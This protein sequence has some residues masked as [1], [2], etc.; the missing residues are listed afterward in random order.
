MKTSG[1]IIILCKDLSPRLEYVADFL[2]DSTG[3]QF[4]VTNE[5]GD[6]TYIINYSNTAHDYAFTITDSGFLH[7]KG[8]RTFKPEI[9]KTRDG[10]YLFPSPDG[11]TLPFDLF[12]AIFYLISR[13]EEYLPFNPDQHGRFEAEQSL[14]FQNHILEE[15]LVDQWII[16]LKKAVNA[17][18]PNLEFPSRNAQYLSTIDIDSPWAF[19]HRRPGGNIPG[20]IKYFLKG[21]IKG[22]RK[23]IDVIKGKLNDPFDV[24]TFIREAEEQYKFRSVFF[25]L[26]A[27]S[28]RYDVNHSLNSGHFAELVR[29]I[30]SEHATGIHPSYASNVDPKILYNEIQKL[31]SILEKAPTLS[32]QHFLMLRFPKTYRQLMSLGIQED[33]SMGYASSP[34]FRAGTSLPFKFYDIEKEQQTSLIVHPFTIMDVTLRQYMKL[35]PVE[36]INKIKLLIDKTRSVC[37]IFTSLW[38]NESLSEFAEWKGW[39]NVFTEM[40][41][42]AV[43]KW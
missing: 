27:G 9:L 43:K 30:A 39:R 19:S 31:T 15:P 21:N 40:I 32:R 20:L 33:Y 23:R 41:K 29:R 13:Y 5:P 26:T 12:S 18:Y 17:A 8:I 37:G 24:Y 16:M 42:E 34:G 36:A 22:V 38:H 4:K 1:E 14:S 2:T 10:S 28:H 25:F 3:L 6:H 35:D 7:E 11:F